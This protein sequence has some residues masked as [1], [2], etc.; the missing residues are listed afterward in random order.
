V[1]SKEKL[2]E[3]A[4]LYEEFMHST[5]PLDPSV[6]RA[7]AIFD[8]ECRNLY[9]SESIDFRKQMSFNVYPSTVIVPEI[10]DYLRPKKPFPS[11]QD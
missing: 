1:I 8:T 5:N 9:Q 2:Q 6:K 4:S 10:L 3:L 11:V 7:K